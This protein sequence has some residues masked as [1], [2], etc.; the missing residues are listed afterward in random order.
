MQVEFILLIAIALLGLV[1]QGKL[2]SVFKKYSQVR[3]RNGMTGG[4]VA[5]KMLRDNGIYD[6]KVTH[7]SGRLTDHYN[8]KTKTVNLSDSVYSNCSIA[9]AAVA[10]HECGH[11]V[12]H[13]ESYAPVM[14]RSAM[15]PITNFASTAATWVILLGLVLM[16]TIDNL[17]VFYIGICLLCVSAFFS[18][19]T[20]PV[21]YNASSRALEW[22]ERER[23]MDNEEMAGAKIS[24]KWAA[25]TYLVAALAAIATVIYYLSLANRRN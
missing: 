12:Q 23:I 6:V 5:E 15:V 14:L 22:L 13:A 16:S 8:P 19:I 24:L 10:A 4:Q 1:V 20:L 17:Y 18:I 3:S 11:A 21:E 7:V 2:D 9:A 25:R